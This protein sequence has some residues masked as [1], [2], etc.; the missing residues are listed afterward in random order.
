MVG[1][2]VWKAPAPLP[3]EQ[4]IPVLL[5]DG[6]LRGARSIS[7]CGGSPVSANDKIL[8]SLGRIVLPD[9]YRKLLVKGWIGVISRRLGVR[10]LQV[11]DAFANPP[12]QLG[13]V[14]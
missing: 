5:D 14:A 2:K 3:P 1:A 9:S 11:P 12:A 4:R 8:V 7:F 10:R 6:G 13:L